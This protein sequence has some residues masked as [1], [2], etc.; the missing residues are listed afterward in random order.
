MNYNNGWMMNG[1]SGAEMGIWMVIGVLVVVLLV[2]LI[3]RVAR[4]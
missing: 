1:G 3:L 4:K 2:F